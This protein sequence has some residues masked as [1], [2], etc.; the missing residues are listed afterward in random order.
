MEESLIYSILALLVFLQLITVI[1][2]VLRQ[3][4]LI[5][6]INSL[7]ISLRNSEEF[8]KN[9]QLSAKSTKEKEEELS[10]LFVFL[11]DLISKLSSYNERRDIFDITIKWIERL[12]KPDRAYIFLEKQ[13]EWVPAVKR[14]HRNPTEDPRCKKT[15]GILGAA[16]E[17]KVIVEKGNLGMLSV[18]KRE[19][20]LKDPL[21]YLEIQVCAPIEYNDEVYG[22]IALSG[23][24]R[25][26][27]QKK[28][29]VNMVS[30]LVASSLVNSM[31]FSRFKH[32]AS[33]DPLT[34][35]VNKRGFEKAMLDAVLKASRERKEFS[36][37]IFDIDFFKNYNDKNGH[38]AGDEALRLTANL[39]KENFR[40]GDIKARYGGEEFIVLMNN[41]SKQQAYELA[42]RFRQK[43][44][45]F[46]YPYEKNQPGGKLTVSGGIA[47]F[48]N[49][50][51]NIKEVVEKAD[52]A[53]YVAKDGGRNKVMVA[54]TI[55]FS[56]EIGQRF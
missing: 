11:P 12:L 43:I 26:S 42:E 5:S 46:P 34:N 50:G 55:D 44:Q 22:V 52:E 28:V 2:Y 18:E 8:I 51:G 20:I 41:T 4:N 25:Y 16:S 31:L 48:P 33:R 47:T 14:D 37:F 13:G 21:S 15:E 10:T 35:L 19:A 9:L 56:G 38:Q 40:S 30:D 24:P 17:L 23:I 1:Y 54:Q 3:R 7:S 36:V 39:L 45:Q 32:M 6:K 29:L 53:L 49:D 27:P